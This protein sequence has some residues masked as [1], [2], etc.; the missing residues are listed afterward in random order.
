M[1]AAAEEPN[2]QL[3]PTT[4]SVDF[5]RQA[6]V[7]PAVDVPPPSKVG[8]AEARY[9]SI[10]APA[11]L[12]LEKTN[13]RLCMA[14]ESSV[15]NVAYATTGE[16]QC[17]ENEAGIKV[18]EKQVK[19]DMDETKQAI[20]GEDRDSIVTITEANAAS[21]G[22]SL[23]DAADDALTAAGSSIVPKPTTCKEE[24]V[25]D[26][27]MTVTEADVSCTKSAVEEKVGRTA[28][29]LDASVLPKPS[30]LTTT[31][32][33]QVNNSIS[34]PGHIGVNLVAQ[35]ENENPTTQGARSDSV[36]ATSSVTQVTLNNSSYAHVEIPNSSTARKDFTLKVEVNS[37]EGRL[38]AVEAHHKLFLIFHQMTPNLDPENISSALEQIE[39]IIGIAKVYNCVSLVRHHLTNHIFQFG[40]D[41]FNAILE[42]PPRW[43]CLANHLQCAPIFKEAMIHLVGYYPHYPWKK[44]LSSM[45]PRPILNL[46]RTKVEEFRALQNCINTELSRSSICIDDTLLTFHNLEK[47]NFDTWF[48]VQLW[49]D[50]FRESMCKHD[51]PRYVLGT[52]YR[53]MAKCGD[54]YL[55]AYNVY[56]SLQAYKGKSFGSWNLK[57]VQQDL[58]IMKKFAQQKVKDLVVNRSMIDVD[59]SGIQHLTCTKIENHEL[60]WVNNGA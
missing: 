15:V 19:H 54:A 40:R 21:P 48:V 25:I 30:K 3:P 42:D 38:A 29:T 55:D 41:L 5:P 13:G 39:Q 2:S 20:K 32:E 22:F 24:K 1:Q 8:K 49:Q 7:L 44:V 11:S 12:A 35:A 9:S 27:A 37:N 59:E 23:K 50:W 6:E 58:E 53:L 45:F 31:I 46:I 33:E 43:L 28:V 57:R 17:K 18:E 10:K 47:S 14:D 26:N 52:P 34:A 51:N 56:Q 36:A 16:P 4:K 60:P